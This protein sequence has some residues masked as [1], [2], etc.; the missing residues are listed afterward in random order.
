M[1]ILLREEL[2]TLMEKPGGPAASIYMPT[3]RGPDTLQGPVRLDNLLRQAEQQLVKAGLRAVEARRWLQ[4]ARD[5]ERDAEF[6]RGQA[7]G[8]A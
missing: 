4:P 5:L 7:D 1:K 2:R 8:L 6:W 3:Q